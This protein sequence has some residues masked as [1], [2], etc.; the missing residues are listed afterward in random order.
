MTGTAL[1]NREFTVSAGS[2]IGR[3]RSANQDRVICCQEYGFF[4]VSD[5]MGGLPG[6]EE[7]SDI[8][9]KALPGFIANGYAELADNPCPKKAADYLGATVRMISDNIYE[10]M[11]RGGRTAFGATL[12]GV[13]LVGDSAVFV[14]LGD[15]RGYNLGFY[16]KHIRQ[17]T[18]DHT[19]AEMLITN[20][21]LSREEARRHPSASALTRFIGMQSPAWP[22]TFVFKLEHGD[23]ILLCSDGLYG[24]VEDARLPRLMRASR[25]GRRVVEKLIGEAN[26]AGGT[27]NI[28]VVYIKTANLK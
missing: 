20:G 4:A 24:M 28:S 22:E 17:I 19:M 6:G 7:T 13:W 11:N 27:D 1:F 21:E 3:K 8:I 12:C 15:S 25:S 10:S 23:R 16:K 5:G 26:A 9:A 18:V 14:N 2:D